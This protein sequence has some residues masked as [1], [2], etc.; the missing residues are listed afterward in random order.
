[1][2]IENVY[3]DV[4]E[5]QF[6]LADGTWVMPCVPLS[7]LGVWK[8]WIGSLRTERLN[9]ANL[10][11]LVDEGSSDPEIVDAVH[12]RLQNGLGQLFSFLHLR[13]GIEC[14]GADLICGS[15]VGADV[16]I[17][18]QM[19]K[20]PTFYHSK[21]YRRAP[22]TTEWLE[23]AMALRAGVVTM[24]SNKS[25]FRR[26]IRGLK[27]LFDGLRQTGQDRLHQLVRSLEAL[28]LPDIGSTK[29]Q[30][31]HRCQTFAKAG[32]DTKLIL[33]EAFDMRSDTEHLQDWERAV[34]YYPPSEQEDVCWQRTRQIEK[35]TCFV[36]SHLL[37][38]ATIR[39]HCRT[40]DTIASFW[41]LPDDKQR[42]LWGEG[43]RHNCGAASYQ[44]RPVGKGSSITSTEI[45]LF[46][47]LRADRRTH[48]ETRRHHWSF[49]LALISA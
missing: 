26:V 3:A 23:Q 19:N 22:I 34:Q 38:D 35:L 8:E 13:Q 49:C 20:M 18:R 7:D 29:S 44:I 4:P 24:E 12:H 37:L 45:I 28:V 16:P 1:V 30:F 33:Q 9:K 25:E 21:G 14:E 48:S 47:E 27:V 5:S 17:I 32:G 42:C 11:L 39:K 6:Q 2:A 46:K 41:K 31:V 43:S 36:Y 10:V 40:D 15:R